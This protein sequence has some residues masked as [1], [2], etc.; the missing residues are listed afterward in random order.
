MT[1][2]DDKPFLVENPRKIKRKHGDVVM[3]EA[4]KRNTRLSL[5][6]AAIW[7]NLTLTTRK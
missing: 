5:R 1:L 4:E 3:S 7:M 6:S 2:E